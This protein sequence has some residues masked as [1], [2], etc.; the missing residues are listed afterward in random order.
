MTPAHSAGTAVFSSLRQ[1]ATM[2]SRSTVSTP[3]AVASAAAW[4]ASGE[5]R[6]LAGIVFGSET[7]FMTQFTHG[8]LGV[9][10]RQSDPLGQMAVLRQV[11][12]PGKLAFELHFHR[13]GGAM[14]LLAD[15]DFGLAVHQRHVELP[16]FM[17]GGADARLLVGKV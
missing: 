1:L 13:P 5:S 16:F 4:L 10:P 9:Q 12:E 6:E 14:A 3:V 15:D 7:M 17:L 8:G 11:A 2:A